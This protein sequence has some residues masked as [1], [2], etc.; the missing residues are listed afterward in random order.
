MV[1]GTRTDTLAVMGPQKLRLTDLK[2]LVALLKPLAPLL[3]G[4][5]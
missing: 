1:F 2:P 5:P 4:L 3:D